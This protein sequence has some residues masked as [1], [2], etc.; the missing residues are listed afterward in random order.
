MNNFGRIEILLAT[1][2]LSLG[3]GVAGYFVGQTLYNAK[4]GINTA[5]VKGLAEKRVEADLAHWQ[6]RYTVSGSGTTPVSE[7]YEKSEADRARIVS[8]ILESG[9]EDAE[10]SPGVIDYEKKE[11]RDDKQTLVEERHELVGSIDVETR[12]V[13]LVS[14]VRSKL[15]RLIA[16]GLDIQ[17]DAPTYHFTKLNEIKPEMVKEATMNARVAANQFASDAGV[18]VGGIRDARQGGFVIRDVGEEYGDTKRIEKDV[19][20]V[21]TITFYLT[22]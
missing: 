5:E 21:T 10:V 8:L 18:K 12:K 20:L 19:R 15:N 9:F 4:V 1:V 7:L 3:I 13:R 22:D 16:Q 11:F 14:E 17:N 2:M 6:I